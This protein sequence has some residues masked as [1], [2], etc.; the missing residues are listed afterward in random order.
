MCRSQGQ[1]VIREIPENHS[2]VFTFTMSARLARGCFASAQCGVVSAPSLF[3]RPEALQC[4]DRHLEAWHVSQTG[5]FHKGKRMV[6]SH[7]IYA[8][9]TLKHITSPLHI[10]DPAHWHGLALDLTQCCQ[11]SLVTSSGSV[12][13][14]PKM[15]KKQWYAVSQVA[16]P[17]GMPHISYNSGTNDHRRQSQS[18]S[19]SWV[20]TL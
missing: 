18:C 5:C 11:K 14:L 6:C 1:L 8:L 19:L 12:A 3:R 9:K 17:K 4:C 16:S 20:C 15:T 2:H 10:W 7:T 13:L